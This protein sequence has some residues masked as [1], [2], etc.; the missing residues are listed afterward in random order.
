MQAAECITKGQEK[1]NAGDRM[2]ALRFFEQS[3][4]KS[5]T[6]QERQAALFNSTAVHASFGDV[7]LAQITLREGINCGLDFK[8]ALKDSEDQQL[9][10]FQGSPQIVIQLQK[11]AEAVKRIKGAVG[12]VNDRTA[13]PAAAAAA[14]KSAYSS[15]SVFGKDLSGLL[16]TDLTGIDPS[17]G[18]IIRRVAALL[19]VGVLLAVALFFVGLKFTF[20]EQY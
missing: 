8:K 4:K 5:P 3:L 19:V 2:G 20:P 6:Q 15:E 13:P 14:G 12:S 16:S 1:Y 7:E 11:F 9:V 18:G 10:K 17:L